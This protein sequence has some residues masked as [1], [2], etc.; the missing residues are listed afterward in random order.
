MKVRNLAF[1]AWRGIIIRQKDILQK[2]KPSTMWIL[3]S[4]VSNRSNQEV[5]RTTA[6]NATSNGFSSSQPMSPNFNS[7]S[8]AEVLILLENHA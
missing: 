5:L 8:Q 3:D 2:V 4:L 7:P 1:N 6:F